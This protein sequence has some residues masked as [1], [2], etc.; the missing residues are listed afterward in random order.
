L[1]ET[2]SNPSR[3]STTNGFV[4][5]LIARLPPDVVAILGFLTVVNLAIVVVGVVSAP[6]RV[7]LGTPLLLF[8]PGYVLVTTLFPRATVPETRQGSGAFSVLPRQYCAL[9]GPERAALSFG[10]SLAILPLFALVVA[11]SRWSFTVDAVVL[12]LSLFVLLGA[13]TSVFTR[14][15]VSPEARF[16]VSILA[17]SSRV[18]KFMFAGTLRN[19]V[20]NVALVLSIVLSVAV[21]GFAFAA[22][23][24]GER[25]SEMTL[26]TET[27]D[28]EY[29]AGEYP[30]V[31]ATG[32]QRDLV[33]GIENNEQVQTEY[34]IVTRVERVS[35]S[36]GS[37]AVL[38]ANEVRRRVVT[39]DPGEQW[40]DN[41]AVTLDATGE[42]LRLSYYLYRDGVPET[43]NEETA[44]RH[45]YIW[46]DV[47]DDPSE[48]SPS[49]VRS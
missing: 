26:L 17:W 11:F 27:E 46:V 49:L 48:T 3:V 41:H 42:D 38:E 2:V 7:A 34:T 13:V 24:D 40:Y 10:L 8:L 29:V 15:A 33:V 44:Y 18:W 37:V 4:S 19:S 12:G 21:V 6:L 30:E 22:P 9:N 43:V 23:Q 47:T 39:L 28:G 25:Y 16:E 20:V 36:D 5:R 35:T 32:E 1:E 31:F 14:S 45:T